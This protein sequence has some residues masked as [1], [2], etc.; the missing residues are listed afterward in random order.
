M[1]ATL[2]YS[3]WSHLPPINQQARRVPLDLMPALVVRWQLPKGGSYEAQKALWA[4]FRELAEED[5]ET[6]K[7]IAQLVKVAQA[8]GKAAYVIINNKAEGCAPESV[9]RLARAIGA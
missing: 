2:C 7:A 5:L 1:N 6:R 4:P 8:K 9:F 3:G